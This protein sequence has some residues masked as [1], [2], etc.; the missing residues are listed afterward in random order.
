MNLKDRLL[1]TVCLFLSFLTL[2]LPGASSAA[3]G[4]VFTISV[5]D[6]IG[7]GW[8][9]FLERSLE[10]AEQRGAAAIIL[11]FDTPGGYIDTAMKARKAL[12]KIPCP[13][14]A[15]VNPHALSAGAYLALS[16]D[17][18]FMAPGATMG[19][20]E[21]RVLGSTLPADEKILST[22]EGEMRAMA[23][24]RGRDPEVAAAMVRQE[25]VLE[26][27]KGKG[28]LLT[29]TAGEA[30]GLGYS[31]GTA[32][33]E[34][35][36]LKFI[37]LEN[38]HVSSLAPS[39]WD[40]LS[41]WLINPLV[42]TGILALAF[43]FLVMEVLT[44]GFGLAGLMSILCFGLYFGGHFFAGVSGWPAIFLFIL[45]IILLLVEAFIPGF[46]VFGIGGLVAITISIVLSSV[47]AV[48]GLRAL[49]YSLLLAIVVG[50][51]AFKFFQ[52]KGILRRFI[53]R[54]ASTKEQ[55]FTSSRDLS[56]L[57]GKRGLAVTPLR[58]AG[59]VEMEGSR[60]NVV[61]EGAFVFTGESVEVIKVEGN[62][63]VVRSI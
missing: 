25:I 55:G 8:F 33:T 43:I 18:L 28:K 40:R 57:M 61:S 48:A 49:L 23:E 36:L 54:D 21:V 37:D 47:S 42:A 15:Y 46:G 19:A 29:L 31:E 59:I 10:E 30:E 13:V 56:F 6:E 14:Y 45:G 32:R 7:P 17:K 27:I 20:A 50:Y 24:R 35:E 11:H 16:A 4:V 39:A 12:D 41:G 62:R 58:P 38:A 51:F 1:F 34:A 5:E 63:V 52:R 26:D 3:E 9:T 44:A 53:H 2:L 22:W 60:Y